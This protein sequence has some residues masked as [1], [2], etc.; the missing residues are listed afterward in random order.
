[1]TP[2]IAGKIIRKR[3][4]HFKNMPLKDPDVECF[5]EWSSE[6]VAFYMDFRA[7]LSENDYSASALGIYGAAVRMAL[8]LLRKPYWSIE[9]E[10]DI[11]LAR[12]H[13]KQSH[14]KPS[15]NA[16]Y[17][18][19][20]KKLSEYLY[21]RRN[22]PRKE[23]KLP[24]EFTIGALSQPLQDNIHEFLSHCQRNW[25]IEKRFER[26][27]DLLYGLGTPMRWMAENA[28]LDDINKLTPQIWYQWLDHRL[29][30][31]AK[32]STANCD[33][34]SLK[35]LVSF[36]LGSGHPV[37]ERFLLVEPLDLGFR[38]PRD[39]PLDDLRKLQAVIRQEAFENRDGR[40]D[41][42]WFLLMLHC[43]LRTCE[44]RNLKLDEIEWNARRIRIEQSK[45]MKDRLVY[46][47]EAVLAALRAYLEVRGQTLYLPKN[48]F[49]YRHMPL[50]RSYCFKKNGNLRETLCSKSTSALVTPFVC[51]FIVELRRACDYSADDPGSQTNRLDP[52]L[53]AA[54]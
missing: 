43:G 28:G 16:D 2:L 47:D 19:G 34:S 44:I 9:P 41:L 18:K 42:A 40:M 31:G 45:E 8:G 12:E 52:G 53:R 22:L 25:K 32:A 38:M 10:K 33:L 29:L 35:H 6:N 7:W 30:S 39:V 15:T 37:C 51:D 20:L 21:V 54:V 5:N 14:R 23:K 49:I 50:S 1:M 3:R 46:L 36:L 11:D 24:W 4:F 13:L 17:E 27:R 48:V 26:G